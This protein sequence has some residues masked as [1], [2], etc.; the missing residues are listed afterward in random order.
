MAFE[1]DIVALGTEI[2]EFVLVAEVKMTI[3]DLKFVERQLK[4]Y[5]AAMRCPVGLLITPQ[6][7]RIYRD[8][9]KGLPEE[10]VELVGEFDVAKVFNFTTPESSPDAAPAF[11]AMVQE[12]LDRLTTESVLRALS[13]ELRRAVEMYIAPALSQGVVRAGHPRVA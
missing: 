4:Q 12:W 10:S 11:Q 8:G 7:L 5:M 1:P 13:A 3:R 9:Y 6:R 2:Q